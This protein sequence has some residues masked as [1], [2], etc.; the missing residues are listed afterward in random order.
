MYRTLGTRGSV[1]GVASGPYAGQPRVVAFQRLSPAAK[2]R[3][4]DALAG[5]RQLAPILRSGATGTTFFA[6]LAAVAIAVAL[7]AL[8]G[9]RW[10]SAQGFPFAIAYVAGALVLA[11][12][13][14]RKARAL[15]HEGTT[16]AAGAYLFPLD[17]VE[18]RPDGTLHVLP[19]G[20]VSEA[21]V[22]RQGLRP[23]LLLTFKSGIT[24][25][26][27]VRSEQQAE[28]AYAALE[29]AQR[30]LEKLTYGNDLADAV[31]LDP[32]FEVRIDDSWESVSSP[33]T[34]TV[35]ARTAAT[36]ALA[37]ALGVALFITRNVLAH[38]V[39]EAGRARMEASIELLKLQLA[40]K[41]EIE[42][43]RAAEGPTPA[44]P[45][46]ELDPTERADRQH[47]R[48]VGLDAYASLAATPEMVP[49]MRDLVERSKK[50]G[51]GLRV[52]FARTLR[53][54]AVSACAPIAPVALQG[55]EPMERRV[56]DAFAAVLSE[57][58]PRSLLPV[59]LAAD[60]VAPP[61]LVVDYT[62]APAGS[63][64]QAIEMVFDVKLALDG[65]PEARSFRLTM[66]PPATRLTQPRDRS[67]FLSLFPSPGDRPDD[68]ALVYARG[69]DRLYDEIY[70]LFFAGAPRVP[71]PSTRAQDLRRTFGD[72]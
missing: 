42:R 44:R 68:P 38:R 27:P 17:V 40:E 45:D 14:N 5:R 8:F 1:F 33:T 24:R 22:V 21:A 48:G 7:Y 37:T 61:A 2:S 51:T 47:Q 9:H 52:H 49:V 39:R 59:D 6:L 63:G 10:P 26:F 3:L 70:G 69:F 50:T 53:P 57:T 36:F 13:A 62:V 12:L 34:G 46:D 66:P 28:S 55:M 32:F 64:P 23:A 29:S 58:I 67:L 72:P 15:S 41:A 16:I 25:S 54:C 19:L 60:P 43:A 65:R 4:V 30:T 71:L 18:A 56:V 35:R 20:G 31:N 11:W